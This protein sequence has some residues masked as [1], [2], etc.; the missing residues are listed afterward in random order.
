MLVMAE[1][2]PAG[3]GGSLP[4]NLV[5]GTSQT[6]NI[7]Y[8]SGTSVIT[9]YGGLTFSPGSGISL[10]GDMGMSGNLGLF[11]I[12]FHAWYGLL[13]ASGGAISPALAVPN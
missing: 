2:T 11:A 6:S 5:T 12:R 13:S 7:A 10:S 3:G 1:N 4:A 8:W 9:G